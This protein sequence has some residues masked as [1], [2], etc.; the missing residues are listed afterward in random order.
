LLRAVAADQYGD[1][2][3]SEESSDAEDEIVDTKEY[4]YS[5]D[6]V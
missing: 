1:E 3:D 4:F 2:D 5:D 6:A